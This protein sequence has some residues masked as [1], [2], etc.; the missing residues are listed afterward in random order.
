MEM[1]NFEHIKNNYQV[2]DWFDTRDIDFHRYSPYKNGIAI[3]A[4]NKRT[5][6]NNIYSDVL[7]RKFN[8]FCNYLGILNGWFLNN[9]DF[10]DEDL[11]LLLSIKISDY[12]WKFMW[13]NPV[14]D[15]DSDLPLF[16]KRE[17][18]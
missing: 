14:F 18:E 12:D 8:L 10:T 4:E 5:S 17:N 9:K 7:Y 3:Y 11:D 2:P 16:T 6:N 15:K 13:G 1:K